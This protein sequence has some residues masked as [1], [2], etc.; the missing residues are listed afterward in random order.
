MRKVCLLK[1]IVPGAPILP[2]QGHRF[3]A[4]HDHHQVSGITIDKRGSRGYAKSVWQSVP[5]S[6]RHRLLKTE[7]V[8]PHLC[9]ES[10]FPQIAQQICCAATAQASCSA[11]HARTNALY[12]I[13]TATARIQRT[14]NRK[15]RAILAASE[16]ALDGQHFEEQDFYTTPDRHVWIAMEHNGFAVVL[17]MPFQ[18]AGMRGVVPNQHDLIRV[19]G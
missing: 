4:V 19:L 11:K 5:S 9:V 12:R 7:P 10:C 8:L 18:V 17:G 6:L 3:D 16:H 13:M 1:P 14:R 2:R 15:V